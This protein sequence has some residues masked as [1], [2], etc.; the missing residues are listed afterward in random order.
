MTERLPSHNFD[1]FALL[2]IGF[3]PADI[4]TPGLAL[5][6]LSNPVFHICVFWSWSAGFLPKQVLYFPCPII[7]SPSLMCLHYWR[8][9]PC[10]PKCLKKEEWVYA[11]NYS[12]S[13]KSH[14]ELLSQFMLITDFSWSSLHTNTCIYHCIRGGINKKNTLFLAVTWQLYRFPCDW[15]PPS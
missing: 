11:M 9:I 14:V 8:R 5:L 10:M 4:G 7:Q 3:V 1:W 2:E 15:L 12:T 13:S 6:H